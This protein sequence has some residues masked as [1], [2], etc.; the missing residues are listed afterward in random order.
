MELTWF[1][2]SLAATLFFGVAMAF[3]KLPSAKNHNR[4]VATFW[5][6]VI[7]TILSFVFFHSYLSLGTPAMMWTALLWGI[8][9]T[10]IVLL[11][12]YALSHV[13][14]NVLFP[15]TTTA[16]LIVTVLVGIFFFNE[17][18][19]ILQT[20]GVILAVGTIF[21]F[22]YKGGKMQYSR[23]LIG[24]GSGIIFI[25]AFNKV[26]QKI[27]SGKFDI[28]V[29]QIYQYLFAAI[30]ALLIYLV[31][32]RRDWKTHIFSGGLGIGSLI[33]VFSF[34]GGYSLYIALTKGPFPLIT[35]IHSLYILIAAL[36]AYFLFKEQ[37]TVKKIFLLLLAIVAV[38]LIRIG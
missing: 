5:S 38:V 4:F 33:G 9:F 8:T 14:T 20:L 17:H 16:S 13:D 28:H 25:S 37:L 18:I 21:S 23:L 6:L 3:Y 22:L 32:H 26:L 1:P 10:C 12:M 27:V 34:F 2:Y 36:T 35:S 19:S 7:P 11:Q 29:F 15:I 30:F 31:L 24:V